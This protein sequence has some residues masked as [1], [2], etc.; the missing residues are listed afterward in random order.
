MARRF[1]TQRLDRVGALCRRYVDEGKF[2]GTDVLVAHRGE[3]VYRDVYGMADIEAGRKAEPDTIY[4]LYSMTKPIVSIALMQLVETGD[5]LLENPV[6]RYIPAFA[7]TRVY[8]SGGPDDYQTVP[9]EREPTVHDMLTHLSGL[10]YGFQTDPVAAI[11]RAHGMDFG[12]RDM[13]LAQTCDLLASLPLL[14]SPGTRWNYGASSDVVGRIVEIVSGLPLD[15]Y[16][17]EHIFRPLGMTDTAFWVPAEKADRFAQCYVRQPDRS[18]SPFPGAY[19][20]KPRMLSGSGGLVGTTDD[21]HRFCTALL[22]GGEL[23]G[24]RIIG[25]KTLEYMRLNHLPGGRTLN[26]LGQSTFAET[27]MDG[28][29]FGLGFGVVLDAAANQ[30]LASAGE[31]MWGGAA[32]TAFWIDPV[33]EVSVVFCTQFL[34]SNAYPNRRQLRWTVNQA[35]V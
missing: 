14:F 30:S 26:E 18:L 33:E 16:F 9:A 10:T 12:F 17:D 5:V 25:R 3:I 1:D 7:Q 35:L 6:S 2:P 27:A 20:A 15:E 28:M 4:R 23:D 22:N 8:A 29:G 32:S 21:Y 11:Y 31:Y 34:P 24:A 19:L 13:D